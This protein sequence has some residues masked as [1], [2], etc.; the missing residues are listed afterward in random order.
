MDYK[1]EIDN[2][3]PFYSTSS[4]INTFIKTFMK[5]KYIN[6]DKKTTYAK[7]KNVT[8]N[9][10]KNKIVIETSNEIQKSDEIEVSITIRNK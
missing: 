4:N 6:E 8:P 2:T 10:L 1:Y 7:I 3:V 5:I 9:K